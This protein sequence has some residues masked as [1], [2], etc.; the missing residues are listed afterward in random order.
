LRRK[1]DIGEEFE[2]QTGDGGEGEGECPE[3]VGD[4]E[5]V[6]ADYVHRVATYYGKGDKEKDAED[7]YDFPFCPRHD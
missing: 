3:D 5:G 7:C 4:G 6:R 1:W 2:G